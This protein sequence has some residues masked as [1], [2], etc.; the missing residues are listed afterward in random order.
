MLR[1]RGFAVEGSAAKQEVVSQ[2]V[3]WSA[4]L[5]LQPPSPEMHDAWRWR[6]E[7]TY[8]ELVAPDTRPVWWVQATY[9]MVVARATNVPAFT[10]QRPCERS[11]SADET[12]S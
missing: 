11:N 7:R 1:R 12:P 5:I 10:G 6:K 2:P 8:P 4:T 3:S 9:W